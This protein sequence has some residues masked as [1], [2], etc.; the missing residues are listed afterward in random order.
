MS[1]ARPAAPAL[2]APGRDRVDIRPTAALLADQVERHGVDATC[3][4]FRLCRRRLGAIVALRTTR[5]QHAHFLERGCVEDIVTHG[6]DTFNALHVPLGGALQ[7]R[8]SELLD[9]LGPERL[10]REL[11]V[12]LPRAALFVRQLALGR[13]GNGARVSHVC[14]SIAVRAGVDPASL[15]ELAVERGWCPSCDSHVLVADD[16]RCPWCDSRVAL[17]DHAPLAAAA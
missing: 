4:R 10:A 14:R 13:A 8:L 3:R 6:A 15:E 16:H 11:D 7:E 2:S 9:A 12:A 17:D 1:T 5:G